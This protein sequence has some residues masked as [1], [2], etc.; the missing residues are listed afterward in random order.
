LHQE[1]RDNLPQLRREEFALLQAHIFPVLNGGKNRGVGAGASDAVFF[2][3]AH[4]RRLRKT[5]RGLRE[6]LLRVELDELYYFIFPDVRQKLVRSVFFFLFILA[7]RVNDG[8]AGKLHHLTLCAESA[9]GPGNVDR[10]LIENGRIHLAGH[11][12][13]PD[14]LIKPELVGRQIGFDV[15]RLES[16]RG[17]ADGLVGILRLLG[18]FIKMRLLRQIRIGIIFL[19]VAADS[20]QRLLGDP[21]G[22]RSHIGDQAHGAFFSQFYAFVEFLGDAHRFLGGKLQ[23]A[24]GFLLQLA[25]RERRQGRPLHFFFLQLFDGELRGPDVRRQPARFFGVGYLCLFPADFDQL[26]VER[27][28][29]AGL[30]LRH[31]IPVFFRHKPADLFFPLADDAH[32]HRL[33]A[34][35]G[36]P[37]FD[38]IPQDRADLIAD[39]TVQD[40]ARLLR[41]VLVE[42][43]RQ[44][45]LNGFQYGFFGQIIEKNPIDLLVF[46]CI[47]DVGDMPGDGFSFAVR[48]GRQVN[49][50]GVFGRFFQ[51]RDGFLFGFDDVIGGLK[52]LFQIDAQRTLRQVFDVSHGGQHMKILSQKFLDGFYFCGRFHDD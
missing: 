13:V 20:R 44:R 28:R 51:I 9:V 52:I 7:F 47:D 5:R 12:A 50:F 49:V 23:P 39:Q 14:Q 8:E 24:R 31:Q 22:I 26:R 42:I 11:K 37:P 10:G 2:Q 46:L 4:Q 18:V 45:M 1:L 33:H 41:L 16:H 27:R 30:K 21:V 48:V 34:S 29:R 15:L 19:D 43:E 25:G 38:F 40:A 32:G 36:E 3:L 6:L 17:R 35:G